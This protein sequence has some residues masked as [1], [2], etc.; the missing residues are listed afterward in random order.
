[1]NRYEDHSLTFLSPVPSPP[2]AA[3]AAAHG[4]MKEDW[5]YSA[6]QWTEKEK[7]EKIAIQLTL[8]FPYQRYDR[9]SMIDC[10]FLPRSFNITPHNPFS[11][12]TR[13]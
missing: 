9:G 6:V 11:K 1:M 10:S 8:E 12:P 3:A 2:P 13:P 4:S 7:E 5:T